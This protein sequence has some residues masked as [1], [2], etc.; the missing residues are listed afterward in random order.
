MPQML[1]LTC[2][3]ISA[4][5]SL[6]AVVA[7]LLAETSITVCG[8]SWPMVLFVLRARYALLIVRLACSPVPGSTR[9]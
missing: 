9:S 1:G 6:P 4:V 2:H 5:F 8:S 7:G 3:P